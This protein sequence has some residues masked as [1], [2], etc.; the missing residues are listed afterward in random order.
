MK[1]PGTPRLAKLKWSDL[2]SPAV[3]EEEEEEDDDNNAQQ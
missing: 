1:R 3:A 2:V